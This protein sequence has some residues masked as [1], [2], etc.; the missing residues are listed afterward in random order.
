ML[1]LT[2]YSVQGLIHDFLPEAPAPDRNTAAKGAARIAGPISHS[3]MVSFPPVKPISAAAASMLLWY[4]RKLPYHRGKQRLS[5]R[6]RDIF[7][8]SLEGEYIERRGG[9]TWSLNPGDS[10][11]Q[12]LF[13]CGAKDRA[14]LREARRNMPPGGVMF[15]LGASIGYYSIV[16]AAE[17]RGDCR[18]YAF[19]PNPPTMQRLRKNLEHNAARGV[20]LCE[21]GLSDVPGHAS[22]VDVPVDSGSSYLERGEGI[23]VTTLDLFCSRHGIERLDLIKIDIE[24]AEL[25]AL[26]GG[27][28]T[29]K[30]FRPAILIELNPDALDRDRSSVRDV[31]VLLE[32]LG[33]KLW[34]V[35]PRTSITRDRLPPS[36]EIVN[37]IALPA[38]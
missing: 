5:Q 21:E 15:D 10:V 32:D 24:G 6:L 8:V 38:S 28:A 33:Y 23:P 19:E 14:E 11:Q 31:V 16:I 36:H 7:G 17:L 37:A 3:Q 35:R 18:V 9:F 26:R 25:R 20:F 1:L 30:R 2:E 22:I 12:D 13:W 29:L 27:Y 34:T 4:A